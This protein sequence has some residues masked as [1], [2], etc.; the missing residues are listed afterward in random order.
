MKSPKYLLILLFSMILL[1]N[2]PIS[3]Y[4]PEC[5][6]SLD[7]AYA[8]I[9]KVDFSNPYIA[10]GWGINDM[11]KYDTC[12]SNSNNSF[13]MVQLSYLAV[14]DDK[15]NTTIPLY[16]GQCTPKTCVNV[17]DM[18][19]L[20]VKVMNYTGFKEDKVLVF[21]SQQ[22]NEKNKVFNF[23]SG[24]IL[25]ILV[26]YLIFALGIFKAIHQCI[27]K[28]SDIKKE[29]TS[30]I[31]YASVSEDNLSTSNQEDSNK[32]NDASNS[33]RQSA[34]QIY[35][36]GCFDF[37]TNVSK[38]FELRN[39]Q[40]NELK[41]FD[42]IRFLACAIVVLCHC[43]TLIDQIPIR[44]PETAYDYFKS[45]GWQI[46]Y[47]GSFA[48]D[49][50]FSLSGFFLAY[51]GI[52]RIGDLK[53]GA[54]GKLA[55][56]ILMRFLRIWPV[57]VFIFFIYW[58]FFVYT[59]DGPLSGYIFNKELESCSYQW[60]FIITLLTNFTYGVWETYYPYCM[61][62]YW[63]I[64]NDFQL[65]VMGTLL[66]L[67]YSK[68]KFIFYTLL[69][70]I[71]IGFLVAE[72][73]LIYQFNLNSINSLSLG[74]NEDYYKYYY[75]KIYT[76]GVPFFV[77]YIF[78]IIYAEYKVAIKEDRETGLRKFCDKMKDSSVLS[79]LCWFIGVALILFL[80]FVTHWNYGEQWSFFV[81]FLYN[82][83]SRKLFI[84]GL[85]LFAWPIMLGN[86]Y[87]LGG[88]L[89]ADVFVPL[90]K[91]SFC[92]YLLH[93]LLI[94]YV[95][96]NFRSVYFFQG[97]YFL[98]YGFSFITLT[99]IVSILFSAVFEMPFQCL[100]EVMMQQA[101]LS[102]GKKSVNTEDKKV[103]LVSEK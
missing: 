6:K 36:Y 95:F 35:L 64:P 75:M 90:A 10:S 15:F 74:Q 92:L 2:S 91:L 84:V 45:F 76:R 34:F 63:Y 103:Q 21:S 56:G 93:P 58:R 71:N 54:L 5:T 81:C 41:I 30:S 70:V 25:T 88:W 48:V 22:E 89:G 99:Y 66:L 8:A 83:L 69:A 87:M 14:V 46:I 79:F 73:I 49:V 32:E 77:G 7:E 85:F 96:L 9:A 1:I 82:L 86:L 47:N 52:K 23:A 12:L 57:Y 80:N 68:R 65:S 62:W 13:L 28:K 51:I 26:L 33:T 39:T 55:F 43:V 40:D 44:N 61:S 78:G 16:L 102:K 11:G 37:K 31:V 98:L 97:F 72:S 38:I 101:K 42:G 50:F 20:K 3:T 17:D 29:E 100:R 4:S 67:Y 59:L 19:T 53:H 60:P 94:K 24:L 18:N 27:F